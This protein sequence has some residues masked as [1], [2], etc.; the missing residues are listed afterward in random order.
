[1]ATGTITI[2]SSTANP[3]VSQG[4][5]DG[6][7]IL[8][9][10]LYWETLENTPS[11]SAA[12]W[13]LQRL[14]HHRPADRQRPGPT[15][16]ARSAGRCA[17]YRADVNTYL[18]VGRTGYASPRARFT[19]S[20]PDGGGPHC[21]SPKARAWWSSIAYCLRTSRS[22]RSSFTTARRYRPHSASQT[23]QGFYDAVGGA[24][25]TGENTTLF[26]LRRK[27]EQQLQFRHAGHNR[28]NTV[29]R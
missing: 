20:L 12:Q 3:G 9:A 21:R 5:P 4:V 28:T 10:Y 8:D 23:V 24:S 26:Y 22:S 25:G 15:P 14:C 6:A 29:R 18:P 7:D 16:T 2:P 11:P 19:V 13:N 1:M 27:L 17:S